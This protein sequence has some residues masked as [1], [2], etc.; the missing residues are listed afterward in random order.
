MRMT[1]VTSE[2]PTRWA[3]VLATSGAGV[4]A[5]FHLGKVPP[6]ITALQGE[7]G[8]DLTTAGWVL[9]LFAAFAAAAA[10]IAGL[11]ADVMQPRRLVLWGLALMSVGSLGGAAATAA[12]L[13]LAGRVVESAGAL[14]LIVAGPSLI[15]SAV[16]PADSRLA[17]ALWATWLPL[18]T[19]L[20]LLASPLVMTTIGWRG[21]WVGAAMATAMS[22]LVLA[23]FTR[24]LHY[25]RKAVSVSGFGEVLRS[26][27]AWVLTATF[28]IYA[29]CFTSVLGF[30]PV[31]LIERMGAT[32]TL[33]TTMAGVMALANVA[34]NLSAGV[35]ARHGWSRWAT[36][37]L[38]LAVMAV[39]TPFI[40]LDVLP[41]SARYAMAFVF[42]GVGGL[43]PATVFGAVP[44]V[45]AS[46]KTIGR[47]NGLVIQGSNIGQLAGAPAVAL[48]VT[49]FGGW[50]A[51]SWLLL[52]MALLGIV[53]AL[54]LRRLE[55]ARKMP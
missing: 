13:L 34:G 40:F 5:A 25:G 21:A 46:G 53:A 12:P 18:G 27:G 6:A 42:S 15:W 55:R 10:T 41:V 39:T 38:A 11:L 3:T 47:V 43:L 51:A 24:N 8:I 45:A 50:P 7:L 22:A 29:F 54:G 49:Q 26:R 1:A 14:L 23:W 17:L 16:R 44:L 2:P 9:S 35:L 30:Y 37:V 28:T 48:V 52:P 4:C 20:M 31:L 32:P 33:A 19:A 36:M